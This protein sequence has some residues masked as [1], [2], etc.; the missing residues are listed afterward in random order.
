M[1]TINIAGDYEA[2]LA[3]NAA[4]C[5]RLAARITEQTCRQQQKKSVA[6]FG[7][8]RCAGCNGLYDQAA[9]L[10]PQL[11]AVH[12]Q[13]DQDETALATLEPTEVETTSE[14]ESSGI[15]AGIGELNN[16]DIDLTAAQLEEL[17]PG[18]SQG[19]LC[20]ANAEDDTG[21][22]DDAWI[23]LDDDTIKQIMELAPELAQELL[24]RATSGKE[25]GELVRRAKTVEAKPAPRR[26]A[27]YMGR[28]RKCSGYMVNTREHQF[29]SRDEDIYRCFNCGWRTSPKY[30]DNRH[31]AGQGG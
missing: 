27:V 21:V 2:W 20:L 18:L 6:E 22:D 26:F 8:L 10:A 1:T 29:D 12:P 25:L 4:Y 30:R 23:E 9:S 11:V 3:G 13:F 17:C 19:L 5:Q 14:S 24:S 31:E 16:L 28:C 7:D 15:D